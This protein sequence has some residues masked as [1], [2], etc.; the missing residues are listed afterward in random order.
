[1]L[2]SQSE[3]QRIVPEREDYS[4]ADEFFISTVSSDVKLQP[5]NSERDQ[6]GYKSETLESGI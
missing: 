5:V 1:M 3:V 6:E 2:P 4:K